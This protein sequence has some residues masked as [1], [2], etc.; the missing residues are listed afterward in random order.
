MDFVFDHPPPPSGPA[1]VMAII[2]YLFDFV[3]LIEEGE[4]IINAG[5]MLLDQESN[6][7]YPMK[8]SLKNKREFLISYEE[9]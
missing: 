8:H 2:N 3:K 6:A 4:K 7:G 1:Q 9:G 5:E